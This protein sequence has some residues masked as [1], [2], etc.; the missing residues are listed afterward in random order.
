MDFAHLK[1]NFNGTMGTISTKS[2]NNNVV[3]LA[4]CLVAKET[5]D[6]YRYMINHAVKHP[7]VRRFLN[8][9][10]TTIFTDKHKGSD[11]AIPDTL[12]EAEQ[13]EHMLKNHGAVG[14]VRWDYL[15]ALCIP[16]SRAQFCFKRD[17]FHFWGGATSVS[18]SLP[19]AILGLIF[20]AR[21]WWYAWF[22]TQPTQNCSEW[23]RVVWFGHG[24]VARFCGSAQ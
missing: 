20:T 19:A 2:A 8:K 22:L 24:R 4:T 1:G 12:G 15:V 5:G 23:I 6:A 10:T 9:P 14:P 17:P 16:V 11:Y 13:A 18:R 7:E 21:W 3:H